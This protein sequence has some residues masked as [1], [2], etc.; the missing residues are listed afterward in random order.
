MLLIFKMLFCLLILVY[1]GS[2]KDFSLPLDREAPMLGGRCMIKTLSGERNNL[3]LAVADTVPAIYRFPVFT[4]PEVHRI[5]S[6]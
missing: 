5:Y 2:Q 1:Q 4:L 3:G 6:S